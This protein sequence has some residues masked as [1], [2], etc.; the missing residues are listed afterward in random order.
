MPRG[1]HT[2]RRTPKVNRLASDGESFW[3]SFMGSGRGRHQGG[4]NQTGDVMGDEIGARMAGVEVGE[5][6][7]TE[8][9]VDVA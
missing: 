6:D 8:I 9:V 3:T 2:P 4:L 1:T 5:N 7:D